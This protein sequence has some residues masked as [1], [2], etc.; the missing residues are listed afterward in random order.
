MRMHRPRRFTR[1][2]GTFSHRTGRSSAH[3]LR[4]ACAWPARGP[5]KRAPVAVAEPIRTHLLGSLGSLGGLPATLRGGSA[6]RLLGLANGGLL[7][8]A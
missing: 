6:L 2:A 5:R 3:D 4:M 7:G 8:E 1:R